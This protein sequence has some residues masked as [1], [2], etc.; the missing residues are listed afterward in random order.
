MTIYL[1]DPSRAEKPPGHGQPP[2][3]DGRQ[4]HRFRLS[5]QHDP[6][7]VEAGSRGCPE[8]CSTEICFAWAQATDIKLSI[9]LFFSVTSDLRRWISSFIREYIFCTFHTLIRVII[10]YVRGRCTSV[11]H[12]HKILANLSTSSV[13][14]AQT[15]LLPD[16]EGLYDQSHRQFSTGVI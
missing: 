11:R 1:A 4:Q 7:E 6:A 15:Q 5:L 3:G 2:T 13:I 8:D 12:H 16:S 9:S 14:C 10:H